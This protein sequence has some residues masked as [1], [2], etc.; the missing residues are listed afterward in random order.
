MTPEE[1]LA[2]LET[3]M[4]SIADTMKEMVKDVKALQFRWALI[5]GGIAILSNLPTIFELLGK[6]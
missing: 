4:S 3:K 1:R 6:K 5:L 2:I